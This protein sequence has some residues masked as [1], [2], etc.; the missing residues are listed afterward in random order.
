[1]KEAFA[2]IDPGEGFVFVQQSPFFIWLILT[3][4]GI[5]ILFIKKFL[6]I[7]KKLLWI[8]F[9]IVIILIIAGLIMNKNHSKN[10][11]LIILGID[12]MDYNLTEKLLTEGKLPNFSYFK[13]KGEYSSLKTTYPPE[14]NVC[15]TSIATGKNPA[16]HGI[17]D[18]IMRRPAD[19]FPYLGLNEV[20]PEKNSVEIR[21]KTKSFWE[22]LTEHKIPCYLFFF[23]NTFPAQKIKGKML[24]GMG[25]PCLYGTMGRFSFY[26]SKQI[27]DEKIKE[28]RGKIILV[29]PKN[30]IIFTY[31]YGPKE[32][33]SKNIIEELKIPLKIILNPKDNQAVIQFQK[34][35]I[36]LEKCSWSRWYRVYFELNSFK[37]IYG[38]VRFYLKSIEP[39]FQLYLTPINFDPFHP[40]FTIS[41]PKTYAG[42]LSKKIGL[43][44]T[45]GMPHDT[46]VL[47][48]GWLDENE[49]LNLVDYIFEERKRILFEELKK[50]KSGIFFFYFDT[51]DAI[52]HMFWRYID[53]EHPLFEESPIYKETINK[54]YQKMDS[55]IAELLKF[56]DKDTILIVLSDHGFNSFSYA[57]H[58]NRW[59]LENGYLKLKEGFLESKEFF[60]AVDWSK[61]K[62]YSLG[63]GGIYI[64]KK[65]REGKGIVDNQQE[66]ILK[67]EIKDR[68]KSWHHPTGKKIVKEVYLKEDIY[69]GNYIDDAFDL[70]VG[71]NAGFRAS[72]QTALGAVPKELYEDNLK[73]WSGDHLIDPSLV[74]GVIFANQKITA[75]EPSI[76][77][78]YPT[79]LKIFNLSLEDDIDGKSIF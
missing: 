54:Y 7:F 25:V 6:N 76:Y 57:V 37:K 63:F 9:I 78:L 53:H 74:K 27:P 55:L 69:N 20:Y 71:F 19:Y 5:F 18:F 41:W 17:F 66:A 12:A 56:I 4:L 26:T 77:D 1:M 3:I 14:S 2:Y 31:I 70:W 22:I 64:N 48:E 46:W 45:Q 8:F 15:W 40:L 67:N 51:L 23:P 11:K 73:K 44:Y 58:L 30:N 72:W 24:S 33:T 29:K 62:A 47:S 79:I 16:K 35:K 43:Y 39:D 13:E 59:L 10:K 60:E 42:E 61:T 28:S 52:Q 65:N 50:F 34:N 75:K 38:I 68:L 21:R 32:K 49:F 36:V